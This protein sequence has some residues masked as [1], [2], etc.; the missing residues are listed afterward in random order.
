MLVKFFG[1][2][3]SIAT[4]MRS[5]EYKAKLRKILSRVPGSG[6]KGETQ[7]EQFIDSLPQY[8]SSITGGNTTC[9]SVS[10]N[11]DSCIV[12]MGSGARVIGDRMMNGKAGAGKAAI[13]IFITHTHW[14]HICGIPFFKPLYIQGNTI[15]FYSPIKDLH[16]RFQYQQTDRFFPL[17][18]DNMPAQ[19]IFHHIQTGEKISM[20]EN[21]EVDCFPLKHP[22]GSF[23]YR[24][25]EKKKTFIF[26]TDV[27]FT[28]EYLEHPE[29]GV[30]R[31]FKNADLLV[32]DAQYT[33][34]ESMKKF[35]WGHTSLSMVI[36]LATQWGIKNVMFTHHEPSYHDKKLFENL[37]FGKNHS[38]EIG[39][40]RLKVYLAR[41]GIMVKL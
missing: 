8:L 17:P 40:R 16:E 29:S 31:F 23:A 34:D 28:G 37:Q 30:D 3:G 4:P 32:M 18:F 24:F 26:A 41:E 6:L 36:N 11:N 38:I 25:R 27:E 14:D 13:H 39:N 7:I 9:I 21:L 15:H 2:R 35:D 22:G 20:G 12:D 19:K 33:L 5:I 10:S 1:V